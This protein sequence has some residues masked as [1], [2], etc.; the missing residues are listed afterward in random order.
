MEVKPKTVVG[1]RLIGRQTVCH[2]AA[3]LGILEDGWSV[4]QYYADQTCAC[5]RGGTIWVMGMIIFGWRM[6]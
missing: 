5:L 4:A 6:S 3:S 2:K 1:R